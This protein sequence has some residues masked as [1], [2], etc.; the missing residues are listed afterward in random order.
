MGKFII[1]IAL[2][3]YIFVLGKC[4]RYP[5]S[6]PH[7]VL[8]ESG[9]I[10]YQCKFNSNVECFWKNNGSTISIHSYKFSYVRG[11]GNYTRDCSIK[12]SESEIASKLKH[13]QCVGLPSLF[14]DITVSGNSVQLNCTSKESINCTWKRNNQVVDIRDRYEYTGGHN[15]INVND[16]SI[17]ICNTANVDAKNWTIAAYNLKLKTSSIFSSTKNYRQKTTISQLTSTPTTATTLHEPTTD[18][19]STG[20]LF[21]PS[22]TSSDGIPHHL[23]IPIT[24]TCTSAVFLLVIIIFLK[25][26]LAKAKSG[27]TRYTEPEIEQVT[28]DS[29]ASNNIKMSTLNSN[30]TTDKM[31]V[32]TEVE[33]QVQKLL[34]NNEPSMDTEEQSRTQV[35]YTQVTIKKEHSTPFVPREKNHLCLN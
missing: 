18:S 28:T 9:I 19:L 33:T 11:N 22:S 2:C 6:Q 34:T 29:T 20:K 15:G 1:G 17:T 32:V 26:K 21:A 30:I 3:F 7:K 13:M 35:E 8:N 24:V 31:D 10:T 25:M 27:F 14:K 12:T 5:I 4:Q 23:I 16:C